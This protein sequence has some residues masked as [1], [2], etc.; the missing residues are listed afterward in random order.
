MEKE[1]DSV[2]KL[3]AL[4]DRLD[5]SSTPEALRDLEKAF[6]DFHGKPGFT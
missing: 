1:E 5:R 4:S 3:Q 2:I 6:V